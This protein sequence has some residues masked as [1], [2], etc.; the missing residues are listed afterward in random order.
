MKYRGRGAKYK[1]Q[2]KV[3]LSELRM[4]SSKS[5]ILEKSIECLMQ[6]SF[7]DF[8]KQYGK[9]IQGDS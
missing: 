6:M 5:V 8:R 3:I 2:S 4:K 7:N 9:Q 1:D